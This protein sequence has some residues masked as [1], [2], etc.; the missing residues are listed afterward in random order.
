MRKITSQM[1]FSQQLSL[2]SVAVF[3][4]L[5]VSSSVAISIIASRVIHQYMQAHWTEIATAGARRAKFAML[6]GSEKKARDNLRVI[7]AYPHVA[8]AGLYDAQNVLTFQQDPDGRLKTFPAADNP[9][10]EP[11][12]IF[13]TPDDWYFQATV[14]DAEEDTEKTA[15]P[16]LARAPPDPDVALGSL[17]IIVSK[18]SVHAL[19]TELFLA[20]VL[21][22][23]LLSGGLLWVF[24]YLTRNI[25]RPI[26]TLAGIMDQARAGQRSIRAE[27]DGPLDIIRM[28]RTFNAMMTQIE[29]HEQLLEDEVR[30]RTV[31]LA[32]S[33]DAALSAAEIRSLFFA[34]FSH[35]M[36]TP[37]TSIM[38]YIDLVS[39]N[40]RS[41]AVDQAKNIEFLDKALDAADSLADQIDNVLIIARMESGKLD[42]RKETFDTQQ[43][44]SRAIDIIAPTAKK[45]GNKL[46]VRNPEGRRIHSDPDKLFH[47]LLNILSNATKF[48]SNGLISV[49]VSYGRHFLTVRVRDSGC[50]IAKDQLA[51]IFEPYRQARSGAA[52]SVRGTGLG[53]AITRC[54]VERLGGAI[55]V[56]S[57]TGT[58][59]GT[60]FEIMVPYEVEGE[61]HRLLATGECAIILEAWL[62]RAE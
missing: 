26:Q 48:T 39:K 4:V 42:L 32:E 22:S 40:L 10:G 62:K 8:A 9:I 57:K 53:L 17:R 5:A 61:D 15:S 41:L 37:L 20:N 3:I 19:V 35:D 16:D 7:A 11:I 29:S 45:A 60:Q 49:R 54:F 24:H 44:I 46:I 33:R 55:R 25:I 56:Q 36:R 28:E 47:I 34:S 43:V 31:E 52:T 6:V 23:L 2:V 38:G 18:A 21:I 30:L 27:L 13:E 59:S 50:G 58:E 51:S 1:T 14:V 12:R